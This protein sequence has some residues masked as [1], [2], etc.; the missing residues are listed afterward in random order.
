MR[1]CGKR[2]IQHLRGTDEISAGW[3]DAQTDRSRGRDTDEIRGEKSNIVDV[4]LLVV[5]ELECALALLLA[6]VLGLVDLGVFWQF[7]IRFYCGGEI[8]NAQPAYTDCGDVRLRASSAVYLTMTSALSSWKSRR[9]MRMMS[10]W[11]IQT[12]RNCA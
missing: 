1:D 3:D 10:P 7:A 6:E 2:V 12:W 11:L 8:S 4:D 5:A 9:E